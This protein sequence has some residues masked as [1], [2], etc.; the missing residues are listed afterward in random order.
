MTVFGAVLAMFVGSLSAFMGMSARTVTI[1][2]QDNDARAIYTRFDRSVRT[3]TSVNRP[4][5]VGN[6]WYVEWLTAASATSLCTQWVLRTDSATLAVRTWVPVAIGTTTPSAW[7]T[8]ATDVVNTAD[9][10]PFSLAPATLQ[11]PVQRLALSFWLRRDTTT[12]ATLTATTFVALNS[13]LG[14]PSNPDTDQN[15]VS[16]KEVCTDIPSRRL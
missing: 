5:R 14:S 4:Q 2:T 15:G 10:Q 1:S 9:Q 11:T 6:N 7:R 3:A 12:A 13:G 16:D 8:V